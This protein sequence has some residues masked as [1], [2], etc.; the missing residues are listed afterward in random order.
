MMALAV[1]SLFEGIALGIMSN[2]NSAVNL[3]ISIL[4]HKWAESMSIS[5]A[6]N[7]TFPDIKTIFYLILM[8]SFVTPIG[9]IIGIILAD[10]TSE[11][12]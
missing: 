4:I 9:T 10:Q 12:V 3:M 2:L 8:Y 5:I 6:L 7:K 11:I 1:H